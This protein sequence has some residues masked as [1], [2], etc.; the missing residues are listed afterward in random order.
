MHRVPDINRFYRRLVEQGPRTLGEKL[1]FLG[2][3]AASRLFG[4]LVAARRAAYEQGMLKPCR[5]EIP[6]VSVGNLTVGGTGK[7]PVVDYLVKRGLTAGRRVAIV[8]RGYRG[9]R[10]TATALVS[11][12]RG[13]CHD[14]PHLY[15]DEP[16][17]LARRN[18]GAIVIVARKRSAGVQ[19]AADLGAELAILDDGFQHLALARD[20]DILLLDAERP[21]G[22]HRLLPAG[23]LREPV[24]ALR[25]S[26]LVILT[27]AAADARID[28]PV[29][30]PLLRCRHVLAEQ[31]RSLEGHLGTW[32]ALHGKRCL[33]FAG[34]ARPQDFFAALRQRGLDLQGEVFFADH[35]Q[36]TPETLKELRRACHNCDLLI[37]TEKDAVKLQAADLP[38]PCYHVVL[39]LEMYDAGPLAAAFDNLTRR[40]PD[41]SPSR[42]A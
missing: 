9:R 21:F 37:T 23:I 36:Y 40:S 29:E 30:R 20:L 28:L 4:L 8:S 12:G 19:L 1:I 5:A 14:D 42:P 13:A 34:I 11:D 16:V 27:R 33:A 35:Q 38:V 24:T 32:S 2:L 25:R 6:V 3:V 7:T 22:N 26:D 41:D 10:K 31:L 39:E 15:G 17:L 18:P